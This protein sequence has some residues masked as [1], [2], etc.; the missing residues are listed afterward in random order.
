MPAVSDAARRVADGV[1]PV[2]RHFTLQPSGLC[3]APL[4]VV[5][6]VSL[7]TCA[8]LCLSHPRCRVF[9]HADTE[10]ETTQYGCQLHDR[11]LCQSMPDVDMFFVAGIKG[12]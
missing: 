9:V 8:A 11:R 1:D 3:Q 7:A 2:E 6:R 12:E 4:H 10:R 5:L